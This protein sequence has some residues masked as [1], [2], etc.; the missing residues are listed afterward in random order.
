MIAGGPSGGESHQARKSQVR[1]AHQ[2]S[3]KEALDIETV[4]DAPI[5]QF[6]RAERSG[7]QTIHNDAVVITAMIA[8][9]EVGRIFIDSRSS[10]DILFGEVYNQMQLGEVSLEKVSTLLY[11]FT[12]ES[13][14]PTKHGFAPSDNGERDHSEDLLAEVPCGG[15][16]LYIQCDPR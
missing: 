12:G 14:A 10:A 7:P 1:E 4:D 3:I 2:I 16:A 5:I 13:R 15:C 8:N 6:G 9:Y 11:G